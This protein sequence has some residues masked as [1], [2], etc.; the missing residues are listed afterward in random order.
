MEMGISSDTQKTLLAIRRLYNMIQY[1]T[2][3]SEEN[4]ARLTEGM[5]GV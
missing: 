1:Q 4:Y 3:P 2:W 5:D